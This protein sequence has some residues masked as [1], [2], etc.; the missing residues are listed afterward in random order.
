MSEHSAH[1]RHQADKC[2]RHASALSDPR[3]KEELRNLGAEY[4]VRAAEIE[5][6]EK[7]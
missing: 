2:R 1:L 5:D 7:E 4:I 6:K 3:T